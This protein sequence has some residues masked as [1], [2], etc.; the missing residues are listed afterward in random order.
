MYIILVFVTIPDPPDL[1]RH[2]NLS[3]FSTGKTTTKKKKKK[4]EKKEDVDDDGN[5]SEENILTNVQQQ[6]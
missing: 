5:K 6:S 4:E 3:H 2:Q 1:T